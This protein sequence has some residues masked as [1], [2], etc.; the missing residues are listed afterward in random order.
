MCSGIPVS[1]ITIPVRPIV[2]RRRIPANTIVWDA[3]YEN[4][5]ERQHLA[6]GGRLLIVEFSDDYGWHIKILNSYR[7]LVCAHS[8]LSYERA[9]EIAQEHS[10]LSDGEVIVRLAKDFA[11]H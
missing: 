10:L 4:R 1:T 5:F 8:N 7:E 6:A 11:L 9:N 3:K 2:G